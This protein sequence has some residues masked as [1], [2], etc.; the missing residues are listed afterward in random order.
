[1]NSPMPRRWWTVAACAWLVACG[2]Q[3]TTC[4]AGTVLH[5]GA[6]VAALDGLTCGA[7]TSLADGA[8]VAEAGG[9]Q[10]P[11]LAAPDG[12]DSAADTGE[13][14][15]AA[16]SVDTSSDSGSDA[17]CVPNCVGRNCGDDGCGGSCGSCG[18]AQK[19]F[20]DTSLGACVATCVPQCTGKNCGSDGCGG[21]C[22]PCAT[23]L[24]CLPQG[25][26][27]PPAWTCN[28]T[29]YAA[30]DACDCACGAYDPDCDDA[31]VVVAGCKSLEICDKQGKC[32]SKVPTA[33]TCQ[34]T[35]YGA[36]DSCDCGCGAVDPDCLF[37][38]L[39]IS[40]CKT[41][42]TC[43]A[44]GTCAKCQPDCKGKVCGDDGCGGKCGDCSGSDVCSGGQCVN[45]CAPKPLLCAS[46]TCGDDGCGGTC[47]NCGTGTECVAGVCKAIVVP[48][49][50]DSCDGSCGS[51]APSGC[52]CAIG[53]AK[54]GNCCKDYSTA[55][56]CKPNCAGKQCGDDGCGGTCGT[57]GVGAPYCGTN[58]Q[59]SATCTKQCGGKACGDDGCGGQCGSCGAESSCGGSFQCVPGSWKCA[60]LYFADGVACDCGCGA[61]DPDCS[62]AKALV[63]GC[64]TPTT[65]CSA[66]GLC[67][68]SFCTGNGACGPGQWC[69]GVYA[70]GGGA[71]QGVCAV[72]EGAA[73][74][75][76]AFCT[77]G[78]ECASATCID[79]LCRVHCAADAD[80]PTMERC[81]GA[82]VFLPTSSKPAGFTGVCVSLLGS[83][84]PCKAQADCEPGLEL[85]SA[86]VDP[87][88]FAPRYLC[89]VGSAAGSGKSCANAT[90]GAGQFCAPS[91]AG[92]VCGLA[93]PGGAADCP[94]GTTCANV[95]FNDH[96]TAD[97]ADD[98]KVAA[99][100]P[101]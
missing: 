50:P 89:D 45:P 74:A 63:Y 21:S 16:D 93:C 53:C 20:C 95:A 56:T 55:C 61:P 44:D 91:A 72:P 37:S 88:T 1:M 52:S 98:P 38:F 62:N 47:G 101:K 86:F 18:T 36:L 87:V 35:Q 26:C 3:T 2:G 54:N 82:P 13:F 28:P 51:L 42:E 25:L 5:G 70:A 73:K 15:D 43:G 85:C 94:A 6:C 48:P 31:S 66:A 57:C 58:Q 49:A 68:V 77:A 4:G 14:A 69:T 59:C 17:T 84:A 40:G 8:C 67:A 92:P 75:P 76:G 10:G 81:L 78:S 22:G 80:C 60:Q 33:W 12:L 100:V 23:D 9:T 24:S 97:P 27:V 30:S 29:Y 71:F 32:A 19:P 65:A 41:G 83:G 34:P 99:C 96:G 79:G 11:D 64:P 39:G 7:G 46:N 90:C